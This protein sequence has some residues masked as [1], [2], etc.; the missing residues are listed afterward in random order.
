MFRGRLSAVGTLTGAEG[1][2]ATATAALASAI[3][4]ALTKTERPVYVGRDDC[5]SEPLGRFLS[6]ST[7]RQRGG[8]S[9]N[10][11]Q[12]GASTLRSDSLD[13]LS[14]AG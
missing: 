6:D 10:A 1:G 5:E 9:F 4:G 12:Y 14:M 11:S 3:A 13:I 2:L 8:P 7:R